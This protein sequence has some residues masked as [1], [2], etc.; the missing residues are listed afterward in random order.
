MYRLLWATLAVAGAL[1]G[2]IAAQTPPAQTGTAPTTQIAPPPVVQPQTPPVAQTISV[3]PTI[4]AAQ[5]E[6]APLAQTLLPP[7]VKESAYWAAKV[8]LGELPSASNRVPE[9][10][11]VVDLKGKGREIGVQGGSL[12]TMIPQIKDVRLMVPFGYARLVGYDQNYVLQPDILKSVDVVE[13]RIFTLHL[14]RGHRWSDGAPFTSEDFE[15]YWDHVVNNAELTPTGPPDFLRVDGEVPKV[16]FPDPQT[17]IYA[18]SKPNPR[19][20]PELATAAE[21]FIYRPAHYL[22]QFNKDFT[23]VAAMTQAIADHKVHSWAALHNALDNMYKFDNPDEPTLQPWMNTAAG[24]KSRRTF[25]RNPY[26]YRIDA[27]GT[28]LPYIDEVEMT[29]VGGGLIPAKANAGEADLQ[30]RGLDFKDVSILKQGELDNGNY[31]TLLWKSGAASQI[32]IYPNLNYAD[33]A[34]RQIL[35][36]VRFRRALS[37]AVDRRIINRTLYFGMATEGA[38]TVLPKSPFYDDKFRDAWAAYDPAQANSLLDEMGL[39]QRSSDGYRM[40][41][42]GRP[43]RLIVETSGE[44]DEVES[45]LQIIV[46]TWRD[47]GVQLIVRPLDRDTLY[48][49]V[50]SGQTMASVWYGW[51]DGI[52]TIDTSPGYLAPEQQDFLAWPKWGQFYQTNGAA[53]E[54]VDMPEPQRLMDLAKAWDSAVS[55]EERMR[56]WKEMLAIHA[57]QVYGIGILSGALQPI[58]VSRKLRNVPDT[59]IWAWEP[60]AQFGILRPDEFFFAR[61]VKQ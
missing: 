51:D 55:S 35:R 37:L 48:N 53:G 22:K 58:V 28:Q 43:L 31:R 59:A 5:A 3:A 9:D 36:D 25:V 17:V 16:T 4:P 52:P 19:F 13:G 50:Y 33:P 44:R 47:I 21:P 12:H 42:D 8:A 27:T 49:R 57:D 30:A 41:P 29:V 39:S 20:L 15:Y 10:L 54:A 24:A 6:A 18:W 23:P 32:A 26:Y 46:D 14:R 7:A 45:A 56:I 34:W 1:A 40:L 2:P 60:G 11:M 38:M 61:E